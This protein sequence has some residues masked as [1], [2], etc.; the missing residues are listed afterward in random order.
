MALQIGAGYNQVTE[1]YT[2]VYPQRCDTLQTML[3]EVDSEI[4]K[5][6]TNLI[7]E[8]NFN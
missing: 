5:L 6:Q 2:T 4:S 8:T 7:S 3:A 1:Q